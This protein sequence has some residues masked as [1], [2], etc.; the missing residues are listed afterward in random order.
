MCFVVKAF[1]I[2][3]VGDS[4]MYVHCTKGAHYCVFMATV[5]KGKSR[6]VTFYYIGSTVCNER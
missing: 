1:K 3:Y 4:D 6:N 2:Y 5:V